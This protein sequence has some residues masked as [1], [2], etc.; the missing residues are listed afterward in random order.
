MQKPMF[1]ADPTQIHQVM[2]NLCINAAHAMREKGGLLDIHLSDIEILH[3]A[4]SSHLELQAGS[5]VQLSVRDTGHGIDAAIQDKIFDPF[6]T[7]KKA[8]EGTGLG[9]SVVYG[10]VKSCGGVID[11][12]STAGQGATFTIYLPRIRPASHSEETSR[13]EV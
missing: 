5:Y 6:F 11:V 2:M 4:L 1:L 10:I 13:E 7:T 8:K 3:P 9:L 12:Q